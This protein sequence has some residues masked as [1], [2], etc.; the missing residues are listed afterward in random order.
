[1]INFL[2]GDVVGINSDYILVDVN[3]IGF[4]INVSR[5]Q[6]FT[7]GND[8]IYTYFQVKEDGFSL[9]G[10][11]TK[12]EQDLFNELINIRCNNTKQF[13]NCN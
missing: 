4:Q 5:P 10:F 11:K 1:M 12:Q 3:G 6:D 2:K 8:L 13:N 7:Y 9:Y